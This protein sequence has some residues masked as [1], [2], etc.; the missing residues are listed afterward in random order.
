MISQDLAWCHTLT[1]AAA[2]H[3][4]ATIG[5]TTRNSLK[6]LSVY[7]ET[8][9]EEVPPGSSAEKRPLHLASLDLPTVATK[10]RYPRNGEHGRLNNPYGCHSSKQ[11]ASLPGP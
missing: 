5:A 4:D 6:C 3:G 9:T 1:T 11:E 10:A 8:S 7:S 2:T